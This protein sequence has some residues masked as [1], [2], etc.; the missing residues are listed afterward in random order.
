M[1]ARRLGLF[2]A[3]TALAV[4]G[5]LAFLWAP[6]VALTYLVV[7]VAGL[8]F[9]A[10]FG[11]AVGLAA[12]TLSNLLVSGLDPVLLVNGP[13]MAL[14]G[15]VGGLLARV[16]DL[17]DARARRPLV[18]AFA[19]F[20]GVACTLVFSVAADS[21]AFAL[22]YAPSGAADGRVWFA[23]VMAGLAFNALPAAANGVLFAL[24]LAPTLTALTRAGV[25]TARPRRALRG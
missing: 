4:L 1:Q 22:Y 15:V 25:A 19:A 7:F 16:V 17:S 10:R 11:G 20:L 18:V 12:M 23:L 14:L 21:A 9:G 2:A 6:N 24:G 13:A 3:F 8:A 5:R